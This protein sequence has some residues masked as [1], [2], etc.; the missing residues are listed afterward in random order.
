MTEEDAQK[1]AEKA[2]EGFFDILEPI[3]EEHPELYKRALISIANVAMM[4]YGIEETERHNPFK[5]S[6]G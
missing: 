2:I 6:G 5:S 3:I 4:S 1:T